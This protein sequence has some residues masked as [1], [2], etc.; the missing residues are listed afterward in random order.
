MILMPEEFYS[1][2]LEIA[3]YSL[4][5]PGIELSYHNLIMCEIMLNLMPSAAVIC[6]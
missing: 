6:L 4:R 5:K 1:V 3:L 2:V